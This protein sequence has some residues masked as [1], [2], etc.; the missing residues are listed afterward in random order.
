M[1]NNNKKNKNLFSD[2]KAQYSG[3]VVLGLNDALVEI[4]GALVGLTIA[5]DNSKLISTVGLITGFAAALSMAASEY[6]SA[7]EDK[8]RK[9]LIAAT[10]TGI[11][12]I[13]AELILIAPYFFLANTYFA[14]TI[15]LSSVIL[16]IAA[17]TKYDSVIHKESFKKKF[18][19]MLTISLG[20]AVISFGFGLLVRKLTG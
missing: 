1:Q 9:P 15:M 20:V 12:Y 8:R 5:L 16:I 6:L 4:S 10:Y 2:G 3:A 18:F 19:E 11:A 13:L 14:T 7:K 17:Y